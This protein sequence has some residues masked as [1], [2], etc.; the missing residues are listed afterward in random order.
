MRAACRCRACA[1]PTGRR[2]EQ[3]E[4]AEEFCSGPRPVG[5]YSDVERGTSTPWPSPRS[6]C[7]ASS[8]PPVR[9]APAAISIAT[10][11]RAGATLPSPR[12]LPKRWLTRI[13]AGCRLAQSIQV[14]GLVIHH[15]SPLAQVGQEK[16]CFEWGDP[17]WKGRSCRKGCTHLSISKGRQE[18]R[19]W[20]GQIMLLRFVAKHEDVG[21]L[22][23]RSNRR[24][25]VG[26]VPISRMH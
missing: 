3:N 23:R 17:P 13:L 22:G 9:A 5:R 6:P 16:L 24:P 25:T 2:L 11:S 12:P 8:T 15:L 4:P 26:N 1:R 10:S 19:G 14:V 18:R 7:S 21:C 20:N